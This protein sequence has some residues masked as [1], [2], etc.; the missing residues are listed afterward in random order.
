M[1]RERVTPPPAP[2]RVADAAPTHPYARLS[3]AERRH[4]GIRGPLLP[5][6]VTRMVADQH[7]ITPQDV[8]RQYLQTERAKDTPTP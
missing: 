3:R 8:T 2:E 7:G 6:P 5:E 4:R 1:T